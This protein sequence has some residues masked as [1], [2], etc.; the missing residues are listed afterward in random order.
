VILRRS[1]RVRKCD[2]RIVKPFLFHT[3]KSNWVAFNPSVSPSADLALW[4]RIAFA[5]SDSMF[6][7]YR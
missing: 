4:R 6:F 3:K 2:S 1:S 5:F 7:H